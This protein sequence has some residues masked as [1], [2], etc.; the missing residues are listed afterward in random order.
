MQELSAA[1]V[2]V[3]ALGIAVTMMWR[4]GWQASRLVVVLM[5][6]AGFGITAGL[7]GR[8]L[9]RGGSL[10]GGA[11]TT[12]TAQ[13]FGVGVPLLLIVVMVTW[14][15][16]DMKERE[17]EIVADERARAGLAT[18]RLPVDDD[19]TQPFRSAVYS[20]GQPRR[21]GTDHH[22]VE[23]AFLGAV[24]NAKG[25]GRL[26]VRRIGQHLAVETDEHR[27]R[28]VGALHLLQQRPSLGG[29]RGM[30]DKRETAALQKVTELVGARSP[31]LAYHGHYRRMLPF[32]LPVT[33]Q[34]RHKGVEVLVREPA[35]HGG[36]AVDPAQRDGL[37][38]RLRRRSVS[39]GDEQDA[40]R[41]RMP[42][43]GPL[44]ELDA[45]HPGHLVGREHGEYLG[46]RRHPK[47]VQ[48]LERGRRRRLTDDLVVGGVPAGKFP[49]QHI[50]LTS[51]F[52][53]PPSKLAWP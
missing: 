42:L 28:A 20:S 51:L 34:L 7:V 32:P 5:L 9:T 39:P 6:L 47:D 30:E 40:L 29:I 50:Q 48:P 44:E 14:L 16:I 13:L 37:Q 38:D 22:D 53:N 36:V 33:Q 27:E 26:L 41:V 4:R 49:L 15:I 1:A 12:G 46:V 43:M 8:L 18:D 25:D 19:R 21:A 24:P 52:E 45:G 3:L 31:T 17:A 35:G 23:G 2:A 10:I 11:I